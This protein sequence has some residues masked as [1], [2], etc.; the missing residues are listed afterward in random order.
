MHPDIHCS[1][2][3][4]SQHM[5][6]SMSIT[7]EW[8]KRMWCIYI[9]IHTHIYTMGYYSAIKNN[10]ILTFVIT[11]MDLEEIKLTEITQIEKDKYYKI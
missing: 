1:I 4:N 11:W 3:Y 8:I 2:I 7:D 9:Y 5:E 10:E 6:A